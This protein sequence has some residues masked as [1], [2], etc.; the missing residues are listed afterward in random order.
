MKELRLIKQ[1][2]KLNKLIKEIFLWRE[3]VAEKEN[4]PPSFIFKDKYLKKLA[5]IELKEANAKSR[6]M[7]IIG[8]TQLTEKFIESFL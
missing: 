4:V 1:G 7:T 6:I 8:D 2:N 5:K 3:E